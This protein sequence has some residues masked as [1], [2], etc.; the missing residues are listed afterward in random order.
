[1][2][3]RL[4]VLACIA[5]SLPVADAA[6]AATL[7]G[8][9]PGGDG[10]RVVVVQRSGKARSAAITGSRDAFRVTGVALD[11]A[12]VQLVGDDGA[13][14]GPI[15]LGGSKTKVQETLRGAGGLALGAV[16]LRNGYARA[17][18]VPTG[19]IYTTGPYTVAARGGV[20]IG[21][22]RLGR[23]KVGNGRSALKGYAGAAYDTD[24]DGVPGVF[25]VD[26]NGNLIL[27]N[28]DRT[29]RTGILPRRAFARQAICPPPPAAVT[30][31]CVVGP[32]AAT[33][34]KLFSNFKLTGL[35]SINLY[36]GGSTAAV[37]PLIDAAF[38]S[39]LTL[40]TQVVG[41][42]T[43]TLDCLGSSYCEPHT[44]AGVPYP[45]VNGAAALFAGTALTISAG[46]TG[47]AQIKP[48]ASTDEVGSGDAFLQNAGGAAYPG[49][50][51]FAFSTA[52]AVSSVQTN[53]A[54]Q[55]LT[56]VAASGYASGNLGMDP[57]T[58]I[59]VGADGAITLKW[60]RP[61]RTAI[62][63]EASPSGWIDIG[64]LVYTADAPN[65]PRS[66]TGVPI[67]VGPGNCP[68]AAYANPVS[69]GVPFANAGTDG[70]LDPAADT[71]ADPTVPAAHLLQFTINAKTCFGDATWNLLT[72]G[73]TFDLDIQAR[74][75]YGDNAARKLYF[76][77]Q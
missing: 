52:P 24:L 56:Y 35:Q 28:V 29:G 9:L 37:Q 69:N 1:M 49:L 75:L 59:T 2:R 46:P 48:G 34:F 68:I 20:P 12:S 67:G 3:R 7:S 41:G 16:T 65:S 36:L 15:V 77:I 60:W 76:K 70:V 19:R 27:D 13:Y 5:V 30:P 32:A 21:V 54:E 51:N 42:G 26:D 58:P 14:V 33:D 66:A 71:P 25:D 8:T 22:G 39:T 31:G 53:G 74:S 44:T 38:P 50:L 64:G 40:A 6:S 23:V 4:L 17:N 72:S 10:M 57:S 62:A 73:A 11:G 43:A 61:Q 45:L 55:A 47:D 63:G 18:G